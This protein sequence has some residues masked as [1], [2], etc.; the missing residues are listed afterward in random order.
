MRIQEVIDGFSRQVATAVEATRA[1]GDMAQQGLG[2]VRDAERA[3]EEIVRSIQ[4][5]SGT[6][7]TMSAAFEQQSQVAEEINQQV[8]HIAELADDS[9]GQAEAGKQSSDQLSRMSRGLKDLVSRF[10]SKSQ[11][12]TKG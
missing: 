2:R 1:G 6:L 8:V 3:L 12:P 9:T 5:I 7:I 11:S 10:V 4:D